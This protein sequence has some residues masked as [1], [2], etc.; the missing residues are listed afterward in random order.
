MEQLGRRLGMRHLGIPFARYT[1]TGFGQRR[2][3][4]KRGAH[5][6]PRRRQADA[7]APGAAGNLATEFG[8]L[9]LTR[10]VMAQGVDFRKAVGYCLPIKKNG[11]AVRWADHIHHLVGEYLRSRTACGI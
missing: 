9:W 3:R 4:C 1:G 5:L 11:S 6:F 10:W 8:I 7:F 2:L